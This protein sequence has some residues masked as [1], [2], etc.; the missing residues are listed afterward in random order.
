MSVSLRSLAVELAAA[1]RAIRRSKS[2]IRPAT[3]SVTASSLARSSGD[4]GLPVETARREVALGA[5]AAVAWANVMSPS[6]A[7]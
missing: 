4:S 1:N 7:T 2:R 3:S 5:G 6:R